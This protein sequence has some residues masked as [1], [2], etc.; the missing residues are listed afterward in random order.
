VVTR[1]QFYHNAENPLALAC[2][3]A[4]SAWGTGRKVALRVADAAS[5]RTLDQM[6]WTFDPLA[7]VPHVMA[8]SPLASETPI[9]IGQADAATDWP[10][11][12][13]LF[14]LADDVPPGYQD[15]RI[16]VEIVG[17]SDAVRLPA[18]ARW[19]HYKQRELPLQAFDAVRREAL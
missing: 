8:A 6:L 11:A 14:N 3:L 1:V 5:A 17:R 13:M 7:F 10:H 9:I 16:V 2:E 15:F 18:R 19:M 4:V 12:D